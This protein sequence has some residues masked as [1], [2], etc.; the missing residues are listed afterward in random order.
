M[1]LGTIPGQAPEDIT[2]HNGH[3][4][5]VASVAVGVSRGVASKANLVAVKIRNA[6]KNPARQGQPDE[7]KLIMRGV[8]DTA[9]EAGWQFVLSDVMDQ[10]NNHNNEGPFIVN[11]SMGESIATESARSAR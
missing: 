1:T 8:T 7:D 6:A 11:L 4:T 3:G 2:D 10:R 9:L 5:S